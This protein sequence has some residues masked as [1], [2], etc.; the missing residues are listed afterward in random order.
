MHKLLTGGL[1]VGLAAAQTTA[2]ASES[3]Q[4]AAGAFRALLMTAM[5]R[6]MVPYDD[7]GDNDA[8]LN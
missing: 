1:Y 6:S 5:A 4:F 8:R 2:Q 7:L 3:D